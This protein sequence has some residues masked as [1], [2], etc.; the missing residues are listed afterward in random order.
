[1]KHSKIIFLLV[2][3][4]IVTA[5]LIFFLKPDHVAA[6][7]QDDASTKIK[8]STPELS[9]FP[10]EN[11]NLSKSALE[12]AA[13]E[14]VLFHEIQDNDLKVSSALPLSKSGKG[15]AVRYN[16]NIIETKNIG[17]IVK[18]QMLEYGLNRSGEIVEI[19]KVDDDIFRWHGRFQQGSPER[20][21]FTITQ[22]QKDQYTI[23]QIYSDKGN[24]T[25]EIKN[26]QGLVQ[27]MDEG[28]EDHELHDHEH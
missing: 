7:T 24:Y 15:M 12:I 28:V 19:E 4:F 23:I 13:K 8:S 27:R 2:V 10:R 16:Q 20:N 18:F 1:M 11:L 14:T 26:G 21:F 17:D 6:S 22:S 5:G 9:I 3:T 25:A